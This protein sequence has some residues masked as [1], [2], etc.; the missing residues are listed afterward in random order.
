MQWSELRSEQAPAH[1]PIKCLEGKQYRTLWTMAGGN[2]YCRES[3]TTEP[4]V[5]RDRKFTTDMSV[6]LP[7]M[8]VGSA[9]PLKS[10]PAT[11]LQLVINEAVTSKAELRPALESETTLWTILST[12]NVYTLMLYVIPQIIISVVAFV[13]IIATI[14]KLGRR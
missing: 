6:D 9:A 11:T 3:K 4:V 13:Y 7:I 8:S 5:A 12:W 1:K 10:S 2:K 14:Y